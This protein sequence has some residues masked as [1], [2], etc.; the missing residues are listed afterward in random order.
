MT[1]EAPPGRFDLL[2]LHPDLVRAPLQASILGR[3]AAAGLLALR[4]VDIRDFS[5]DRHRTVDDAPY[6]GGAGMVMKVDV[7]ARAIASV[8]APDTWVILLSAAGRRFDQRAA[9][10][11]SA[12][13]HV[14]LVCGHYEGIDARVE[15]LVDE[16]ISL[17]DF[18]L[19]GGEIAALAV[20]DAVARLRP[21]VLGNAA[22]PAE[23][24]FSA[25]LLEHPQYTRPRVWEGLAVPDV[26]LSGNH[27]AVAAWRRA[28]AEE[29]TRT[30][31][32]DLWQ[33]VTSIDVDPKDR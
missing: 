22:S 32:P 5:T 28:A 9:E 2:T 17:G 26:L 31:R 15:S 14:V 33:A 16:E 13:P 25:G 1:L 24:S 29:R 6:G 27:A 18:V 12:C 21:G 7:V 4:V 8:R 3:A 10:R 23:E 11:L 20:V 30:R 19:T